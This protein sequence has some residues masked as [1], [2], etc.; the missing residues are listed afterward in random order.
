[1]IGAYD[2]GGGRRRSQILL[3]NVLVFRADIIVE[4]VP[5]GDADD[6]PLRRVR[7]PGRG[8]HAR[9]GADRLR[10]VHLAVDGGLGA[11]G[12]VIRH[13]AIS[14]GVMP[15][16]VGGQL[17]ADA[18]GF[19]PDQV[20]IGSVP[21]Q[22]IPVGKP[23]VQLAHAGLPKGRGRAGARRL[24]GQGLIIV[25]ADPQG[26]GI[27][28]GHPGKEDALLV[29][30]GAG[31]AAHGLPL[32]FRGGARSGGNHRFEHVDD[33]VGRA[34]AENPAP[35]L[36]LM[37]VPDDV[38]VGVGDAQHRDGL[39][40]NAAVGQHAV[41][42]GHLQGRDARGAQGKAEGGGVDMPVVHAHPVQKIDAALDADPVHQGIGRR[43]VM[44][45]GHGRPE[46]FGPHIAPA[47]IVGGPG[48]VSPGIPPSADGQGHVVGDGGRAGPQ[49]QGGGV[50]GDGLDRGAH[51]HLHV[52]RPV[53][54]FPGGHRVA[55]AD[56][57]LQL[58]R[59]VIQH[60]A[61]ALGL[62]NF[63][64]GAVGI[65][66]AENLVRRIPQGG[67]FAPSGD[68]FLNRFLHGGIQRQLHMVS[69]GPQLRFH[70]RPVGGGVLQPVDFQENI[71]DLAHRV[72]HVMGVGI[73][74]VP[75]AVGGLQH[76]GRR[77]IQG[78]LIL[79][80]GDEL[81]FIHAPQHVIRPVVGNGGVVDAVPSPGIEI[82]PG[83]I[84]IRVIGHPG[85]HRAFPQGQFPQGFAEIAL[86][87]HLNPVIVLP[88]VDGVQVALQDL[89]LVVFVFQLH[90]QPGFLDL[91]LIADLGGKQ[92]ILD[93]LLGNGGSALQAAGGQVI[94]KGADDPLQIHAG[95]AVK[96]G[97]LHGD[98]GVAQIDRHRP[99]GY[100]DPVL[101]PLVF[102]DQ[103]AVAVVD[104]G[105]LGLGVQ[106]GQIQIRRRFHISLGDAQ[107]RADPGD[108]RQQH[109]HR[110]H[111]H[112]VDHDAED[113]VGLADLGPENAPG[114]GLLLP[115]AF[116]GIFVLAAGFLLRERIGLL[117]ETVGILG[118]VV[119]VR[120]VFLQIRRF[121][122]LPVPPSSEHPVSPL[123]G[124]FPAPL[125]DAAPF[126]LPLS[127]RAFPAGL[128]LSTRPVSTKSQV[129]IS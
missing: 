90:R 64:I 45:F 7:A 78:R 121:V 98:E 42:H 58:P 120:I 34:V 22:N 69:A 39:L 47:A 86:R 128:Q 106:G 53:Q 93:Q 38:A 79:L 91:P 43:R 62:D 77:G 104:K 85:E 41:G 118:I 11:V 55:G 112:H 32:D 48:V 94:D 100:H 82:P 36:V 31:F 13:R 44:G 59:P 125:P 4:R 126:S 10:P 49:L 83:I 127:V 96:P 114:L 23:R 97:V 76:M 84:V 103:I 80:P 107:Q 21:L 37:P 66:A 65:P 15:A 25:V 102:R 87:R 75:G 73:H 26:G 108:P 109:Q 6:A 88:E 40:I 33:H 74:G 3:Q 71:H 105:G 29:R 35:L 63:R 81:V 24:G 1:M 54:G 129:I 72:F 8:Q 113:E 119:V 18:A 51:G 61:R 101:R 12:P 124:G 17:A 5:G 110:R 89:L 60:H 56:D 2:A 46:G 117:G 20:V 50:D 28:P 116:P 70:G 9:F 27:V 57:G 16:G 52:R 122:F 30:V 67:I 115:R 19:H 92:G 95:M 14:H 99:Q 68:G 111:P 123:S